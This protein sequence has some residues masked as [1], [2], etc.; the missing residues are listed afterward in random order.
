MRESI[1]DAQ[2][3]GAAVSRWM[4]GEQASLRRLRGREEL[5]RARQAAIK[6]EVKGDVECESDS[7]LTLL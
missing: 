6:K 7:P 5:L 3:V 4:T 1:S 2:V